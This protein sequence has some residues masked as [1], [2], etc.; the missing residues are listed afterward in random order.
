[1]KMVKLENKIKGAIFGLLIGDAVGV[2]YEFH[3]AHQIPSFD[4]IDMY[5]PENFDRSYP[6]IAAGTWSDDGAHALCLLSSLLDCKCLNIQDFM[7]RLSEWYNVGYMAVD[8]HVFDVGIQTAEA[9]RKYLL[10]VPLKQIAPND[11][12]ANGNGALMRVL[13]LALWHQGSD[14]QLIEDAYLQSHITH[15]HLRSKVCCA[16]YC[17]WARYLLRDME[18]QQAWLKA[19]ATLREYYQHCPLDAEQLEFYI[20]PDEIMGATGSG[21]VV[22]CLRSARFALQQNSYDKVIKAAIALGQDTDTTACVA[23]G[24]AGLYYGFDALPQHW[25]QQLR[26]KDLVEPLVDKLVDHIKQERAEISRYHLQDE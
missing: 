7:Y 9:I 13:P 26:A 20:R 14:Q 15:G 18:I 19:V 1:M 10:G 11:E 4:D 12:H 2:P 6:H 3:L 23:G 22:D 24:I 21:Y 5:P 25:Y 8:G 17:L 16:L